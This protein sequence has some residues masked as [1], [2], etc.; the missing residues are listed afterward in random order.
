MVTTTRT[1]G[2][3][4]SKIPGRRVKSVDN[5]CTEKVIIH[6]LT[7]KVSRWTMRICVRR[8]I[9]LYNQVLLH[10]FLG[11]DVKAFLSNVK[12]TLL[13]AIEADLLKCILMQGASA[14]PNKTVTASNSVAGL[15]RVCIIKNLQQG[16]CTSHA[17]TVRVVRINN[18]ST[19]N[20]R[21]R[22]SD[23]GIIKNLQQ[24]GCT[25]HANTVRV[26]RI[27]NQ[28]TSNNRRRQSDVDA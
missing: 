28:S 5:R 20:N 9:L 3:A 17:N 16:G 11:P 27:N 24:G 18:Q 25:S 2:T 4:K 12:P 8:E 14:A 1:N 23:V 6:N 10:K 13:S 7:F 21:R 15:G 22:Q 19:S 26:V